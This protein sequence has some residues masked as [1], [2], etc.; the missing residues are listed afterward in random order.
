MTLLTRI[1][2][3]VLLS[4]LLS[5]YGLKKRSL[6]ASGGL[7]AVVVGFILTLTNGCFCAALLTF[8]LT[9]SRLTKWRGTEKRKIEAD[10]KEG[11]INYNQYQ[12][13][14]TKSFSTS[15]HNI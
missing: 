14:C 15:H 10:Y 9:S 6:N 4:G 1:A 12:T 7:A 11:E 3:S 2:I 8:F 5:L 13:V